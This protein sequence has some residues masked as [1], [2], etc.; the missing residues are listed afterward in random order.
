MARGWRAA[1]NR[2]QT[3][4][5][6][7]WNAGPQSGED[8]ELAC[9]VSLARVATR[10]AD[11]HLL[12]LVRGEAGV[13][14]QQQRYRARDHRRRHRRSAQADVPPVGRN[15]AWK[16]RRQNGRL[17]I[18]AR[19]QRTDDFSTRGNQVGLGEAVLGRAPA[20]DRAQAVVARCNGLVVV[21]A[22]H[23]DR[24]GVPDRVLIRAEIAGGRHH[25]DALVP[26]VLHSRVDRA[27]RIALR[28][29]RRQRQV[30]RPD[31]VRGPILADPLQAAQDIRFVGCAAVV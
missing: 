20:A 9:F 29:A 31:V 4:R 22:A 17:A 26:Q 18:D 19:R 13:S 24:G 14:L 5:C 15:A 12:D 28:D 25:G 23:R 27:G 2:Q 21:E 8:V 30:D 10:S 6:R 1:A 16:G 11:Q 7:G 3:L